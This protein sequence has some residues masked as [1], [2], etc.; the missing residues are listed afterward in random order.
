MRSE[1]V[2]VV[3][4]CAN[5]NKEVG[6]INVP[7]IAGGKGHLLTSRVVWAGFQPATEDYRLPRNMQGDGHVLRC[8]H[9][10]GALCIEGE[11]QAKKKETPAV[12]QAREEARS[13][14]FNQVQAE[15]TVHQHVPSRGTDAGSIPITLGKTRIDAR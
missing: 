14:I 1:M 8:P 9:C 12:I 3:V 6:R 4:T 15:G 10:E 7:V 13:R 5:E 11:T 2:N